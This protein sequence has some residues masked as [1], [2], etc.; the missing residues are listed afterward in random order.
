MQKKCCE[1]LCFV[2][3][4]FTTFVVLFESFFITLFV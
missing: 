4:F 3:V 2:F 1:K